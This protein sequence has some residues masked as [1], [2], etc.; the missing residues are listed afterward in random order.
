[1]LNEALSQQASKE[2]PEFKSFEYA[3]NISLQSRVCD[4]MVSYYYYNQ[5]KLCILTYFKRNVIFMDFLFLYC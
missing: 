2:F 5:N 3:P 4:V 1:M